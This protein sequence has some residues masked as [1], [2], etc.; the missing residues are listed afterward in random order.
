MSSEVHTIYDSIENILGTILGTFFVIFIIGGYSFIFYLGIS[1]VKK[2]IPEKHKIQFYQLADS[3]FTS[4]DTLNKPVDLLKHTFN[5]ID[6]KS[7]GS[8]IKYGFVNILEDY[9][10]YLIT[11]VKK[12]SSFKLSDANHIYEVISIIKKEL[13]Q[14]PFTRLP[15]EQRRILVNLSKAI[16]SDDKE[17]AEINLTQLNDVLRLN[18]NEMEKL[19][20]Q[21]SWSIPLSIIGLFA[22]LIL[23]L[24]S[25]FKPLSYRRIRDIVAE[26]I[27]SQDDDKQKE[28]QPKNPQPNI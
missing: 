19:K 17:L 22:T 9:Y 27:I 2:T 25:I 6:R 5:S 28:T 21:T 8:L 18:K 1:G 23:G 16:K 12:D 26:V 24:T 13:K 11:E 4:Q 14:E 10:V 7:K 3:I 15:D 20:R